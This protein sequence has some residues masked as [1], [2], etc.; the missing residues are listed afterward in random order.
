MNY[1]TLYEALAPLG[2]DLKDS[3]SSITRLQKTI[4][5]DAD[6]GNLNDM[7]KTLTSIKEAAQLLSSRIENYEAC[8]NAF[9]T[10]DYFISGDFSKQLLASCEEKGVNVKG[11]K[12]IYEM[13][14]YKIRVAADTQEVFM[15]RKKVPSCRPS[16]IAETI[17]A[18]QEKLN[19]AVFKSAPFL[20][21]L[22]VAYEITCLRSGSRIGSNQMLSK[23]YKNLVLMSR[24][25][26]EYDMQAFAFDLA[27]LY[28]KGPDAWIDEKSG[29][30][31]T[32]GTSRVGKGIRVLSKT[33]I[34]TYIET[35]S[36]INA[37][38]D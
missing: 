15:D 5:K 30:H 36:L 29:M 13:F 17:H 16:F 27:R 25:R 3:V 12:G 14:P 22:A 10:A 6:T 37:A 7:Q 2:K 28:E 19:K 1:E 9:D 26:K 4:L 34:E 31:Y 8:A 24:A 38:D 35:L 23:I 21:E 33:G 18:G 32:F 20:S 11:E